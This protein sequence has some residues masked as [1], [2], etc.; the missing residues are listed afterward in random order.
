MDH[1]NNPAWHPWLIVA[2]VGSGI[3]LLA[4]ISQIIQIAVSIRDRAQNMDVTG[5]PWDGRSLEW[6]TSSP[7]PFYNFATVPEVH[8]RDTFWEAKKAGKPHPKPAAYEDIH[9]PRNTAGGVA[10]GVAAFFFGFGLIWHIWWMVAAGLFGFIVT[11]WVRASNDDVDY[12][13]PAAEVAKI[14]QAR[15]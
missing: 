8:G 9:M 4:V 2:A 12:Y 3:I 1:Y 13:V 6:A 11:L 5:D 10:I 15:P 14:E 7:P